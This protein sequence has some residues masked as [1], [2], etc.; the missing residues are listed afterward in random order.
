MQSLLALVAVGLGM[1]MAADVPAGLMQR[2]TESLQ[3]IMDNKSAYWNHSA[4]SMTLY[5]PNRNL[6][7]TLGSGMTDKATKARPDPET[8]YLFGSA[9]SEC[10]GRVV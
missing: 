7:L 6:T 1:T 10:L 2:L 9:T 3:P 4:I 5:A 8:R